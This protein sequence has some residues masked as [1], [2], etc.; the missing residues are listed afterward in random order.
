M[1]KVLLI[2]LITIL[3]AG[4]H[5]INNEKEE[6]G[7]PQS[8]L[9]PTPI[10]TEEEKLQKRL[11]GMTLEEKVAQLF[12]VDLLSYQEG[13]A[14][15]EMTDELDQRL[16]EYPIGGIVFFSRD[17]VDRKQLISLIE[18]LQKS[19]DLPLFIAVDE[20]GGRVSR[21]GNNPKV[22]ITKLPT[23]ESIGDTLDA[24]NAYHTADTLGKE[25]KE[26]GFNMD[27]APVADVNSNPNNPVIGDRSFSSDPQVAGDM[28]VEFIRGLQEND[29]IAFAKHFPGHGDTSAD[30]HLGGVFLTHDK[31]RL[32]SVEL[33]PF[34]NAIESEVMGI[35]MAHIAV[36]KLDESLLP[37]SLSPVILSGLLREEMGYDG[38]VVTDALNMG[39]ITDKY[40][41]DEACVLALLAGN[42]L[43][44]MPDDFKLGYQGV[45]DAI[46]DGTITIERIDESVSRILRAKQKINLL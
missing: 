46:S 45:L 41:A 25:L 43:L 40:S 7:L 29:I 17:I 28:V 2:C 8:Q 26:L 21:L 33:V 16:K 12:I 36:P 35:M 19:R 9:P 18:G 38:L 1:K 24:E 20:E 22:G 4:C 34:Y 39:A 14:T 44:L 27:F 5:L 13:V 32:S 3:L 15:I 23:A 37:A 42:D 30:T 10:E 6:D 31:D 11:K